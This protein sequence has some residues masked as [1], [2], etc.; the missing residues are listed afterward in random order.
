MIGS[1]SPGDE[2]PDGREEESLWQKRLKPSE[3]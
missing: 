1:N 3:Y 2:N